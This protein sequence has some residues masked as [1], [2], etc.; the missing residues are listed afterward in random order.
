MGKY[1]YALMDE[2][3]GVKIHSYDSNHQAHEARRR[4]IQKLKLSGQKVIAVSNVMKGTT[5][6]TLPAMFSATIAFAH[7]SKG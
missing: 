6:P 2:T 1:S 3:G 5:M 4:E 7:N